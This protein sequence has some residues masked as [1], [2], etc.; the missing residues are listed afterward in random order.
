MISESNMQG[1]LLSSCLLNHEDIRMSPSLSNS[2]TLRVQPSL[3]IEIHEVEHL[4]A[5]LTRLCEAIREK[6][7]SYLLGSIYHHEV[8]KDEYSGELSDNYKPNPRPLSVFLCHLIDFEHISKISPSVSQI[9]ESNLLKKLAL[10]KEVSDFKIYHTQTLRSKDNKEMDVI[11]M[12]IPVTSEELKKSFTS[13]K[14]KHKIIS[15]VQKSIRILKRIRCNDCW[16]WAIHI[17]C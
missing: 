3:S 11:L 2:L 14:T 10:G 6:R 16:T 4:I 15:K 1:Y 9:N 13:S 17:N 8:I 12:A 5:G 7:T